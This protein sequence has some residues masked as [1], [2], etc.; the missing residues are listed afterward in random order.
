MLSAKM[1]KCQRLMNGRR[2]S[3]EVES[4]ICTE[5]MVH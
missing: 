1:E 5:K 4:Y 2:V 3:A